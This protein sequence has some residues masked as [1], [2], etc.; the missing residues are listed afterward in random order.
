MLH[1]LSRN[2]LQT[3]QPAY[4]LSCHIY[5]LQPLGNHSHN[6]IPINP[7]PSFTSLS[8]RAPTPFHHLLPSLPDLPSRKTAR[9]AD[10][11][12]PPRSFAVPRLFKSSWPPLPP[13]AYYAPVQWDFQGDPDTG[14]SY[15]MPSSAHHIRFPMIVIRTFRAFNQLAHI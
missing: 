9:N 12:L 2:A 13:H 4:S 10:R 11:F 5:T 8:C 3:R 1:S 6:R 7:P 15:R 14:V